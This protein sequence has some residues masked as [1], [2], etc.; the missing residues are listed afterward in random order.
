MYK[1]K[2]NP[3]QNGYAVTLGDDVVRQQLNGGRGRYYIDVKRNTDTVQAS[4]ALDKAEYN[5]MMAFWRVYQSEPAPFLTD[6]IIDNAALAEY[7]VNFI[8]QTFTVNE[9]SG[10][11]YRISAQFEVVKRDNSLTTD[12]AA[13]AD[14]VM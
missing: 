4:W 6:L 2:L 10:N 12:R 8:P 5:K 3:E 13:I 7:Q 1:L 14:W 9:I 11:L